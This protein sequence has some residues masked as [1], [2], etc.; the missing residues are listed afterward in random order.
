MNKT[1]S[2]LSFTLYFLFIFFNLEAIT[3]ISPTQKAYQALNVLEQLPGFNELVCQVEREGPIRLEMISLPNESFDAFW[4]SSQR[5]IRINTLKNE[6]FNVLVCSI[7]F[8]LHN[9]KSDKLFKSYYTRAKAGQISKEAY[10]ENVERME[11]NN[12]LSCSLLLDKGIALGIFSEKAAW[13]ILRDFDDHYKLQQIKKHSEWLS[14]SYEKIAP[15]A[16]AYKPYKGTIPKFSHEDNKDV[17]RYLKIKNDLE[18]VSYEL[19]M[20]GLVALQSEYQN[21]EDCFT[22]NSDINCT[23]VA[24]RMELIEFVFKT[25][26]TYNES[27]RN[28]SLHFARFN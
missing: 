6:D 14:L 18:S 19:N 15:P 26:N 25:N 8:E 11:H 23:R 3:L 22:G 13:P 7:L 2:I 24:E 17:I 9:A 5:K 1:K 21:L 20:K 12:A 16:L 4:D 27:I 10:V 28:S